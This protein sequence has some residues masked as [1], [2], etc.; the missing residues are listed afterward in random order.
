MNLSR[1]RCDVKLSFCSHSRNEFCCSSWKFY[2]NSITRRSFLE[3]I[4]KDI[5]V[6]IHK[7]VDHNM[8]G[9]QGHELNTPNTCSQHLK[10]SNEMTHF[11]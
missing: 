7:N 5:N 8:P 1:I 4:Q 6:R 10:N 2:G 9:K 3:S 11:I